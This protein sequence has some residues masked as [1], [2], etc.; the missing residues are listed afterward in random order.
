MRASYLII[1][2]TC[3]LGCQQSSSVDVGQSG[4]SGKEAKLAASNSK[5]ARANKV[6]TIKRVEGGVDVAQPNDSSPV[7][8]DATISA[9]RIQAGDTISLA[10]RARIAPGWHIYGLVGSGLNPPTRIELILP[11]GISPVGEWDAPAPVS[12]VSPV[13]L[14][15]VY[16]GEVTFSRKLKVSAAHLQERDSI[17][18]DFHYQACDHSRC[19]RP[20]VIKLTVPLH[21]V[22]HKE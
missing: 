17:T 18:C 7:S 4:P 6:N 5:S 22:S 10:I 12:Q 2:I 21:V 16:L 1:V 19:M 11:S 20:E 15:S 13:G 3:C 8:V 9:D 14:A